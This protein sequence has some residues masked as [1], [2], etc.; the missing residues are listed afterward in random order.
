MMAES[1][2]II[3]KASVYV[4]GEQACWIVTQTPSEVAQLVENY[5]DQLIELTL[6]NFSDWGGKPLY[7]RSSK[8]NSISPPRNQ[9]DD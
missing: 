1:Q 6:G 9:D 2:R 5:P 3:P 8:I 7:V 4:D